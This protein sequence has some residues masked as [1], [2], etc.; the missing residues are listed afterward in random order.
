MLKYFYKILILFS[1][2]SLSAASSGQVYKTDQ[3]EV[4]LVSESKTV[5]PGETLW[6]A[7]R[8][9][10]IE[11]WHTY[12]KFGGDSGVATFTSNWFVPEGAVVGDIIWPIPEWTPFLGSELVTFTY[13]REVFLPIPITVPADFAESSFNLSTTIDWQVCEEICIPGEA[14]F[15]LALAVSDSADIDSRWEDGFSEARSLT[16][17]AESQHE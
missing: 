8:L 16:P 12:W 3:I 15:A 17:V 4:E 13:E 5:V 9:D 10:P 2:Y 1:F 14:N 7:I 11:H 6:L